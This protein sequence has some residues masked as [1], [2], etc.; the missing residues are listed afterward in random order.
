ME[1]ANQGKSMLQYYYNVETDRLR[2]QLSPERVSNVD[3]R[4]LITHDDMEKIP[5]D[6]TKRREITMMA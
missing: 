2:L 1:R 5:K 6:N 3:N 4:L